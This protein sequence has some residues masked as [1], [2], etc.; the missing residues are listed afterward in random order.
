ME[1]LCGDATVIA[2]EA[3]EKAGVDNFVFISAAGSQHL[4]LLLQGYWKG[5][6]KAEAAIMRRFPQ[7][8]VILRAPGIYGD[9]EVGSVTLPLGL[10]MKPAEMV[11]SLPPF[12]AL[13]NAGPLEPVLSPPVSVQ[14]VGKVAA[15]GAL[16]IVPS[17][18][19]LVDDINRLA[20][21][22]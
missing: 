4:H 14:N 9:R 21:E 13:R 15:G 8:G 7:G 11:L 2:T 5:K 17:G 10:L 19:L 22:I 1:K 3:A 18:I 12:A 20:K 6:Q 16:G